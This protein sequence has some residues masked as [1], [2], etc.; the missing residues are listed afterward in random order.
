MYLSYFGLREQPFNVTPDPKFLYFGEAYQ[1]ALAY[2]LYG[3]RMRKGFVVLTGEIGIGKTTI[4]NA[5][6]ERLDDS[7][8]VAHLVHSNMSLKDLLRFVFRDFGLSSEGKS[9]S[10]LLI[11]LQDFLICLDQQGGNAV[12]IIDE[13]QNLRSWQLEEIRLLSNIE[14]SKR[15]L[16]QIVL[17]GQPEL[18]YLINS[19]ELKQ[20]KQ[21]ISLHFHLKALNLQQMIEYIEHRLAMSG[22]EGKKLF[23]DKAYDEVF[24]F[25]QGI[26]RLINTIC[27]RA[28]IKACISDQ[29]R[30]NRKLIRQVLDGEDS[31]QQW[32]TADDKELQ[33]S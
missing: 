8:K 17:V 28:L 25:S 1:D 2:L 9:K 21:R 27:D 24:D 31:H 6:L 14:T 32:D 20:F 4:I 5:L 23:D 3:I 19:V 33:H 15:K 16:L 11:A 18:L 13:A 30:I 7:H 22:Y 10:E 26:P 12:L 29:R